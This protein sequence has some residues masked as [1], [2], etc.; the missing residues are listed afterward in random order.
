MDINNYTGAV[1]IEANGGQGG[2]A[3]D[4]GNVGRCYGA[5]G[6]GGGGTIYFTGATPAVTV[7]ASLGVL[8][9]QRLPARLPCNPIVPSIAGGAGQIVPGY[10]IQTSNTH[11]QHF[12]RSFIASR[13]DFF[14]S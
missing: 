2:T 12:M 4:G 11:C 7:T 9:D 10:S 3:N 1:T 5:G 8:R 13:N 6:G 14:Q